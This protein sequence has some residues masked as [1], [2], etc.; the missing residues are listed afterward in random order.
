M[1]LSIIL[2]ILFFLL[3]TVIAYF[4]IAGH[5]EEKYTLPGEIIRCSSHKITIYQYTSPSG[6]REHYKEDYTESSCAF[7]NGSPTKSCQAFLDS[8]ENCT[9]VYRSPRF[10]KDLPSIYKEGAATAVDVVSRTK[11]LSIRL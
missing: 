2:S 1:K 3:F 7:D 5:R 9:E 10:S 6:E 8:L 11:M 4:V